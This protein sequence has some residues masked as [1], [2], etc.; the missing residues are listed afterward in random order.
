MT[1]LR[2]DL[3]EKL[4]NSSQNDDAGAILLRREQFEILPYLRPG[5]NVLLDGSVVLIEEVDDLFGLSDL[6]PQ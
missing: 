4:A 6:F 2:W 3:E 1:G 5:S